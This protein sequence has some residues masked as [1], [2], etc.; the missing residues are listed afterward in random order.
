[1]HDS[2][3]AAANWGFDF[4]GSDSPEHAASYV[5]FLCYILYIQV[6]NYYVEKG[7]NY[8]IL[9]KYVK[10]YGVDCIMLS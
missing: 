4:L 8:Y 9:R 2:F 1:M 10:I 6:L 3:I 7:Y 5:H